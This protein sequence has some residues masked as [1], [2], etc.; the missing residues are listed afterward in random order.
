MQQIL[1]AELSGKG[2]IPP[3]CRWQAL[4]GGRT[5]HI[6]RVDAGGAGG[7]VYAVKLY[8]ENRQTPLFRNDGMAEAAV[9]ALLRGHGLA[10]DLHG[11]T[12]TEQ[13]PCVIY[14]Y[15]SGAPWTGNPAPVA[16]MLRRLHDL[17]VPVP[18]DL[19]DA[20]SGSAALSA[21]TR[22]ILAACD[23]GRA[24][25][26]AAMPMPPGPEVPPADARCLI[27]GDAVASNII[28]GAA[29]GF[30]L[31]DW[32]CPAR[33]EPVADIAIVLSPAMQHL[34][35]GP[36]PDARFCERFFAAYG[37]RGVEQRYR[38]LAPWYHRRMAAYCLWKAERGAGDYA[39]AMALELGA[40]DP[41][42][43]GG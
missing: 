17:P 22:A 29:D 40:F 36:P 7:P 16:Q 37:D 34:Y 25:R 23:P 33:G 27:H 5:N 9:L 24:A 31:I 30:R 39:E 32:Q 26:L 8:P 4:S 43:E 11:A 3:G 28:R 13:G 18:A 6:W 21:Q 1:Q 12:T 14:H 2:L 10:P 38:R 15:I 35:G 19:P 42:G 20:P 41:P